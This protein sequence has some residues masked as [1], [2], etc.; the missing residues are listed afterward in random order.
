MTS[1]TGR[2]LAHYRIVARI[3]AGVHVKQGFGMIERFGLAAPV[4]AEFVGDVRVG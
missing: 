1:L 3:G 4:V 2:T